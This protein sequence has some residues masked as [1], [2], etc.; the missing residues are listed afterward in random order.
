MGWD[1]ILPI[2]A[3]GGLDCGGVAAS[4]LSQP[5]PVRSGPSVAADGE[6][7]EV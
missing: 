5:G 7:V 4:R 2:P 3:R 6:D 1:G